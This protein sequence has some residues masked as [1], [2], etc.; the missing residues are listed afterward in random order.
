M[1]IKV[2]KK[3]RL[4]LSRRRKFDCQQQLGQDQREIES[5][6]AHAFKPAFANTLDKNK[7][8]K[9][10]G[11]KSDLIRS[12]SAAASDLD[13]LTYIELGSQQMQKHGRDSSQIVMTR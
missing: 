5:F 6:S 1:R 4:L 10:G 8:G 13:Q 11:G 2:R 7:Q 12:F 9:K 3:I